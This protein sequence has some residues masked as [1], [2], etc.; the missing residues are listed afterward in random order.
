[1]DQNLQKLIE[2]NNKLLK[3]NLSLTQE[4]SKKIK[5]IQSH[6][7]RTMVGKA[8]Y[9]IIIISVTI[10]A[11]YFSK[12]YIDNAI[13]TYDTFRE[14]VDRSSNIINNPGSVFKD[15]NLVEQF[16]GS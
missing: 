2:E 7:R 6:I 9:W 14:N 5:K 16:F 15:V 3:E 11:F 13:Q 12:P 10:G 1:M 8:L 4:N